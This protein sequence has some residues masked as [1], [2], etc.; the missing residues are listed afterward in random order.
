MIP[1]PGMPPAS[2]ASPASRWCDRYAA[3]GPSCRNGTSWAKPTWWCWPSWRWKPRKAGNDLRDTAIP[4][5]DDGL[6]DARRALL[7]EAYAAIDEVAETVAADLRDFNQDLPVEIRPGHAGTARGDR[8]G[9][10]A[11]G[12]TG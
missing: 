11:G 9:G 7:A 8:T 1:S 10:R 2:R 12:W 5:L 3:S 4:D 6:T